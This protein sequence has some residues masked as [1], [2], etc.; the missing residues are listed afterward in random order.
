VFGHK[1]GLEQQ[2][3]RDGGTVAW[4]TIVNAKE[5][6]SSSVSTGNRFSGHVTDHMRVTLNVQPDGQPPFEATLH[7]AFSGAT[8]MDG[9]QAKVI[10]DPNDHS[11]IA[12]LDDQIFPP[13]LSHDQ[14]SRSAEIRSDAI[15][16]MRSGNMADF[17]AEMKEKAARGE[18][19]VIGTP[20]AGGGAAASPP[21]IADEL[22]KLAALHD[23]GVLTDDEFAAQK[24]KLL[25]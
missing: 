17:V 7:Q 9:W 10:Y 25:S 4:A 13:G 6:W 3:Q 21:D 23:R 19:Q 8:P 5:Q 22:A 14:M 16:A 15:T 18:V 12:I 1:K 11:K 2:L 24:A 20:I